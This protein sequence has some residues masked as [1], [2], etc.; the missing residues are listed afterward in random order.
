MPQPKETPQR[1]L[2]MKLGAAG[3]SLSL[4]SGASAAIGGINAD[5]AMSAPPSRQL[6]LHEEE[7]SDVS[8]ATFHVF[9][10]RISERSGRTCGSPSVHAAE[11]VVVAAAAAAPA[12]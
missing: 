12:E 7:I 1:K 6:M 10:K 8:L 4:A 2:Q 3:L 9:E 11:A 5:P